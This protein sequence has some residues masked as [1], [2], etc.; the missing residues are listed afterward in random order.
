[1]AK[2]LQKNLDLISEDIEVFEINESGHDSVNYPQQLIM[3]LLPDRVS[4]FFL[5]NGEKLNKMFEREEKRKTKSYIFQLSQINLL[6]RTVEH[7]QKTQ[8]RLSNQSEGVGPELRKKEK[9]ED[10]LIEK[11]KELN[12][13][14]EELISEIEEKEEELDRTKELLRENSFEYIQ[15]LEEQLEGLESDK[16][17]IEENIGDKKSERVELVVE[18]K[19]PRKC[20][21]A[22]L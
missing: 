11:K 14:L 9:K 3:G 22:N 6:Q 17:G 2:E 12:N 7:L 1:M 16:E 19:A 18:K 20:E 5:F 8:K 21:S 4:D 10:E 15:R 13:E